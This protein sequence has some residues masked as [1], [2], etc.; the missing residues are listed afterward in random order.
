MKFGFKGKE[1]SVEGNEEVKKDYAKVYFKLDPSTIPP[2]IDINVAEG[3]QKDADM[4]GIYELKGDELKIC[5]K[6]VGKARPAKF[7]S[8]E[9]ENIALIV[10]KRVKP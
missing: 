5:V 4:E 1:I 2:C 6:V 8:P 10:L 7:A 9:G 3:V